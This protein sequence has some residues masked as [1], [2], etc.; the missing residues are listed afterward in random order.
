[1]NA[2]HAADHIVEVE[3]YIV[4]DTLDFISFGNN[5]LKSSIFVFEVYEA[6]NT[7]INIFANEPVTL[8]PFLLSISFEI[9]IQGI[10]FPSTLINQACKLSKNK[11]SLR[12]SKLAHAHRL[13]LPNNNPTASNLIAF[14]SIHL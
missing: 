1:L 2:I 6:D 4:N 11:S 9:V 10:V 7:G 12:I 13:P 8:N 5:F 3:A 14:L